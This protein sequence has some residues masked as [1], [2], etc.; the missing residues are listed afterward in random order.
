MNNNSVEI[1]YAHRLAED[2]VLASGVTLQ[3]GICIKR[4][5]DPYK[6][7]YYSSFDGRRFSSIPP[8]K[9]QVYQVTTTVKE[10]PVH[11]ERPKNRSTPI[12]Y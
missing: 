8:E 11:H 2:V 7:E 1:E 12:S 10:E 3:S 9:I 4:T 5:S 6:L